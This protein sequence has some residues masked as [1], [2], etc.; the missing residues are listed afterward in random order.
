MFRVNE[1]WEWNWTRIQEPDAI[2]FPW[3]FH[4]TVFL[5]TAFPL[6]FFPSITLRGLYWSS[7]LID[8]ETNAEM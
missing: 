1:E 4:S 3:S 8:E 2:P 6:L 5:S 7:H